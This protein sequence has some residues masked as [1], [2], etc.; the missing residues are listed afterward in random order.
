[1]C[2]ILTGMY[3]SHEEPTRND[4]LIQEPAGCTETERLRFHQV[5]MFS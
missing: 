4:V 2:S 3:S 1:M 5:I